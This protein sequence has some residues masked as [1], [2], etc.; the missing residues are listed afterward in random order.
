MKDGAAV[1]L[2]NYTPADDVDLDA[3]QHNSS[4]EHAFGR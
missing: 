1:T 2:R 4:M 3:L